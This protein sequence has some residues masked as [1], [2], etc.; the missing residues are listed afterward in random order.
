MMIKIKKTEIDKMKV[1]KK[2]LDWKLKIIKP[3]G[4]T[5]SNHGKDYGYVFVVKYGKEYFEFRFTAEEL[6]NN[7]AKEIKKTLK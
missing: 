7:Y 5:M 3:N 4:H 1:I 2:N 6:W